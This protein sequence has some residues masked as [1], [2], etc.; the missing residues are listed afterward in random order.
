V[1]ISGG[2]CYMESSLALK[3]A[4]GVGADRS[5]SKPIAKAELL[6]AVNDLLGLR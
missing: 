1:A 5:V 3:V 2:A 6:A 4:K